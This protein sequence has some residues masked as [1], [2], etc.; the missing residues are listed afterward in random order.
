SATTT[1]W[2]Y[3]TTAPVLVIAE[4]VTVECDQEIPAASWEAS[5]N[6]GELTEAVTEVIVPGQC[7][8]SYVIQRTYTVTDECD[9]ST[10][11][12]QL[13]NVQD[14]TAPVF[15]GLL[16]IDLPCDN[17]SG[18]YVTAA[19][20]CDGEVEIQVVSDEPVSG[21]CQG[22]IIRTYGAWDNCENYSEFTQIITLT[23]EVAPVLEEATADFT[24]EC[25]EVYETPTAW[26]SDNCDDELEYSTEM[27][28]STDGCTTIVTYT[29][30]ATDNCNN[31]ASHTVTVTI[32]DTTDP[33]VLAPQGG[34]FECDEE[35]VYGMAEATD[36]CDE[37]LEIAF[38]DEV[39]PGECPQSFSIVRTW[40]ATDDC[41]NT[42]SAST[43]YW[44]YDWTAPVFNFVP[45]NESYDCAPENWMPAEVSAIDNCGEVTIEV[46]VDPGLDE[47]GNGTIYVVYTASDECGNSSSISY[48]ATI[49]DDVDPMLS[50]YPA[51]MN[52]ECGA[53][54]PAVPEIFATDNCDD[55]VTVSYEQYTIGDAPNLEEGEIAVCDIATPDLGSNPC[56]YP[57]DWAMALFSMPSTYRWYQVESGEL[58]Q[59][60]DGTIHLVARMHNAY[61][62]TSGFD[63][64]VT[65]G[66]GLNWAAWSTQAFMTSFK[67]DCNGID[68]NFQDWM[69]YLL[70]AGTGTELVGYG[71]YAGSAINLVHAPSNNYFGFQLGNGANNLSNSEN[72]F[73]GWFTYSGT[74]LVNGQQIMSGNASGA[75][76]FALDLDCCPDYTVVRCWTA[77]DCSGNFVQHCQNLVYGDGADDTSNDNSPLE[78]TFDVAEKGDM[79]IVGVYPNPAADQ[80]E[81]K[82]VS[83]VQN[84]VTLDVVDMTGRVV[85]KIYGGDVESELVYK[86][87]FNAGQVENGL[88]QVRLMSNTEAKTKTLSVVR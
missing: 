11:L 61:D 3:D 27:A 18:I 39:F 88:Y 37:E 71:A 66:N 25:D 70:Q 49:L 45:E 1:Y 4:D 6:C 53:D 52:M 78:Q 87:T 12:T 22:R 75:G 60:E 34:E 74:F 9:N 58:V 32:E 69:Y 56:N 17:Y 2:V 54:L 84:K 16:E 51:D 43:T 65:F 42:G 79:E 82:F 81:I 21:G 31:S 80:V 15:E 30:T 77:V 72:G 36:N 28:S 10:S 44:V 40:T 46:S 63:V 35:I 7:E 76:D 59:F 24:V 19:D 67:A 50:E 20:N 33:V 86:F 13:I 68:A 26:F 5:D 83:N 23:D 62:N 85:A 55:D 64:D 48:T 29:I 8:N 41:G 38:I 57:V 14:T 73:G 47:C